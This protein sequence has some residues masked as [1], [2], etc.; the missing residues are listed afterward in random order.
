MITCPVYDLI[1]NKPNSIFSMNWY[2][3]AHF[4]VSNKTKIKFGEMIQKQIDELEPINS[5][6]VLHY[7]YYAKRK[8][9]DLDNVLSMVQK[10]LQDVLTK[11]VLVEDHCEF[12]VG[13]T[14]RFGGYDKANPRVEVHIE[15]VDLQIVDA[16]YIEPSAP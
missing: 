11:H 5:P 9:T 2:R 1:H 12:I 7:T 16:F 15:P 6:V 13:N 14:Q 8:R 10:C 4:H 3:N